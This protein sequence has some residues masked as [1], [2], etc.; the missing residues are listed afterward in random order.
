MFERSSL[1][2]KHCWDISFELQWD[3]DL[4]PSYLKPGTSNVFKDFYE[5]L[6]GE[7]FEIVFVSFDRSESDLEEYM[8]EAHGDWYFIPLGSNEIQ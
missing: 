5:E 8:Q 3:D 6:E 2:K 1:S 4:L 7:G